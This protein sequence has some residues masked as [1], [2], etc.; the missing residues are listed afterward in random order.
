MIAIDPGYAKRGQGSACAYFVGRTLTAVWF[1]R[2][3]P[4]LPPDAWNWAK[5]VWEQPQVDQRTRIAVV[6]I[7]RLAAE[8]GT[9]AGYYA[10][11]RRAEVVPVTPS[12]WKGSVP[13]PINHASLWKALQPDERAL[14]PPDTEARIQRAVEKGALERW[15]RPGAVYYGTWDAHN[16][17]DAVGIG[18]RNLW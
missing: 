1:A 2:C 3:P 12:S 8:G 18:R 4:P 7:V 17:L 13:K 11:L 10:G 6:E 16:L 5:V 15:K 14:F 9:L